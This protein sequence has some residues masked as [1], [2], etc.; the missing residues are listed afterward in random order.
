[1]SAS[2]VEGSLPVLLPALAWL[3]QNL[4]RFDPFRGNVEPAP[5]GELPAVELSLLCSV[6]HRRRELR[7]IGEIAARLEA[8]LDHVAAIERQP[9]FYEQVLRRPATFVS[10]VFLSAHL[11][12]CRSLP[13]DDRRPAVQRLIDSSNVTR[14][15][16]PPHRMLELRYVLDVAG[17]RH[18]LPEPAALYRGTLLAQPLNPIYL[19]SAEVYAVTHVVFYLTDVGSR[20]GGGL[21]ETELRRISPL[22]DV[23]LAMYIR[24]GNWDVTGELALCVECLGLPRRGLHE[25]AWDSVARGQTADGFVVADERSANGD[26]ERP[27]DE[28]VAAAAF[29]RHYHSTIVAALLAAVRSDRSTATGV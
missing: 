4:E 20:P 24:R 10:H 28:D 22:L 25:L 13:P 26:E 21:D 23:L 8:F 9:V 6:L 11:R 16:R 12:R 17:Y 7:T 14:P 15:T 1:V 29:E 5:F 2:R 19:S 18:A 3:E 27:G